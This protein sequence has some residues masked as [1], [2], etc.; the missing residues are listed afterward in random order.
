VV[1][2]SP[3]PVVREEPRPGPLPLYDL[4]TWRSHGIVAGITGRGTEPGR[5]FDLGLWTD[6]PVGEVMSRWRA[7]RRAQAG[8]DAVVLGNQIHGIAV[9]SVGPGRGWIHIDGVDG[10]VTTAPGT[11]LTVTLADC[12]PIYLLVPGRGVGLLHAGWRGT[13]NGILTAGLPRLLEATAATPSDILMHLGVGIC[14][15]CYEV[16]SEV[17][18]GCAV[19]AD[20]P[21]PWH[22]DLR[23]RLV[24]QGRRLGIREITMSGWCSAHDRATFYSHRASGGVDGRMVAYLGMPRSD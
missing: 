15:P 5:G 9:E 24:E 16:G 2:P 21:G 17:M 10:W 3:A 6:A 14:G 22:V 8:F 23:G 18:A 7:F 19:Q 20:G 4:P 1:S 11:L 13:A 12:I